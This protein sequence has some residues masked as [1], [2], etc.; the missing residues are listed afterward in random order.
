[1][2]KLITVLFALSALIL[3]NG[4]SSDVT[5]ASTKLS[6]TAATG[7][8]IDGTVTV[9][10][11]DGVEKDIATSVDGSF[12]LDVAGMKPPY[13]VKVMP[14]SGPTLYSFAAQNGQTVN[15]TPTTNLAMFLASGKADLDAMYV[16]WDGTAVTELEVDA[17]EGVVRANLVT[18]IENAGL[19]A[20]SFDLFTTP[21]SADGSGIDGVM[22]DLIITINSVKATFTFTDGGGADLGFDESAV[23]PA[24]PVPPAPGSVSVVA[25]SGAMVSLDGSYSTGCVDRSLQGGGGF[26]KDDTIIAGSTMTVSGAEYNDDACTVAIDS[27]GAVVTLAT[28]AT[29]AITGWIGTGGAGGPDVPNAADGSGAL[30]TTEAV[31]LLTGTVVSG[32]GWN[33]GL[34][35]G[36]NIP[37]FFVL[38]DT[39]AK[40]VLY[41]DDDLFSGSSLASNIASTEL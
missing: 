37:L 33:A 22:D 35:V 9:K 27:G 29:S 1:M 34:S 36:M 28:G 39:G 38:D 10:D 40:K 14:S 2:K 32:T 15:L 30:G 26:Y 4:C 7:A 8:P 21:F 18:E 24:P 25:V 17:A 19:D 12:V 11:A 20:A 3:I 6:G 13:L 41:E 31:T 5:S 23:P 16:N